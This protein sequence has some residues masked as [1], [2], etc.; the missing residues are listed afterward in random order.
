MFAVE[1]RVR[2]RRGVFAEHRI[3]RAIPGLLLVLLL[4]L[5]ARAVLGQ[6]GSGGGYLDQTYCESCLNGTWTAGMYR[7]TIPSGNTGTVPVGDVLVLQDLYDIVVSAGATLN[8]NGQ[9]WMSSGSEIDNSGSLN[10]GT[11]NPSTDDG[12]IRV[13]GQEVGKFNPGF[14]INAGTLTN[15]G[16]LVVGPSQDPAEPDRDG[17]VYN[18]AGS[19]SGYTACTGRGTIINNWLI[20]NSSENFGNAGDFTNNA[21]INI[22]CGGEINNYD[23]GSFTNNSWMHIHGLFF[24][25]VGG[26]FTNAS[27]GTVQL[28]SHVYSCDPP[29]PGRLQAVTGSSFVNN[30]EIRI[31]SA[32]STCWVDLASFTNN[33]VVDSYGS[34]T[35]QN[36]TNSTAA[37]VY[38]RGQFTVNGTLT[39]NGGFTSYDTVTVA[40]T[41]NNNASSPDSFTNSGTLDFDQG[42][43][44]NAS[45]GWW[46]NN[47]SITMTQFS[48]LTN[49]GTFDT[50][51][52]STIVI[53]TGSSLTNDAT[54]EHRGSLTSAS[55]IY[56]T[57]G[58]INK[59]CGSVITGSI[60]GG[61][62]ND[63][64]VGTVTVIKTAVGG[65]ATF[66]Y[67]GSGTGI[68]ASFTITT[69]GGTGSRTFSNILANETKTITES[70]PPAGWDF[71]SVSCVDP[72]NGS[73][74]NQG[75]R[76]ATIDLDQG[77]TV[78]CTFTNTRQTGTIEVKKVLS[79]S[80]DPGR[81]NL[82]IDGTTEAS[83]VGNSGT[84]GAITAVT[85][86]HAV[87]E[88]AGTGTSLADYTITYVCTRNGTSFASGSGASVPSFTVNEN[89]TIV[90]TFTNTRKMG[91]I[92]VKKVLSPSADPGRFNLLID[93]TTEASNVGNGG[94]T[95]VETVVT[96]SHAV[97]E[98]AGTGTSLA[99]Y[100]ITY[101]CTR[102]GTSFASGSGASVPSFTVNENDTI[103]CTFTNTRKM[104]TIEVKK[105]LSPSADPGRFNLLIDGTT[106]ASNVGNG[107]TT[108]VE[109][110]V[111]GSHAVSETAGTGTSLTDYTITYVCTR[112]GTQ[113]AS[114]SGAS[115]P[116]FTVNDGD[117]IV[118]TFTNE[119]KATIIIQKVTQPAGG[120]GFDFEDDIEVPNAFVLADGETKT[121]SG[122]VSGTYTVTEADPT[123]DFD[124]T[125]ITCDDGASASPSTGDV[126]QR[127]A[128]IN[129]DPGETVTCTFTNTERG[130]IIIE[131]ATV[132]AGATGFEFTDDVEP[133]NSFILDDGGMKTF[134][135]VVPGT[136]TVT[137]ADPMGTPGDYDLTNLV[138]VEDTV[139]NSTEDLGSRQATIRL[140][141][142][143]TVTCTFT[144][145][146]RPHAKGDVNG[147]GL[148]DLMD[149]RMCL[150]I[151]TGFLVGT[152]LQRDAA[153]VDSDGDV[154]MD[155]V[156][157]L[158]EYIL[159]IRVAFP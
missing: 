153:D 61:T 8:V 77:E 137:E 68:P 62:V 154:D 81:F 91:T 158:S 37:D 51:S 156:V 29:A 97:S 121:F 117:T 82:R 122:L 142:G 22:Y 103:V 19:G 148:V 33:S 106:E 26:S 105:V 147:D 144:N 107:G 47:G 27:A 136:Y 59:Y 104:G 78:T 99:D 54:I 110:V 50:Y 109:T 69:T 76:T 101:V 96:G 123:P 35:V 124:L 70:A 149:V 32:D 46:R 150:Q 126:G 30:G 133:P 72:D 94:T 67:T 125:A 134:S 63:L 56:N 36:M 135:N 87:S 74:V 53:P 143:E 127:K 42:D 16:K 41:I 112:N 100:T 44:T 24:Q 90:C 31:E 48:Y 86:S 151:A 141:P 13:Y 145:R 92:E 114:G 95:G 45:G 129:L 159:G 14:L 9:I 38:N 71:T 111:T 12:L 138:C 113:F 3:G 5:P 40:G 83:N 157:I 21:T 15:G 43:F 130:T 152:E 80:T 140:D 73:T 20:E 132:P 155:D 4:I 116:S 34:F 28:W 39:N 75:T 25:Y 139:D 2:Q 6:C 93:G 120:T 49:H 18:C 85:G 58:T 17:V 98:T 65:D 131:K 146:R 23:N 66:S 108:G 55:T 7:C 102:N 88:T 57:G 79:P 64:C 89:D 1:G 119:K 115:V 11:Y 10:I 118:C 84:T 128:T 52:G 60:M